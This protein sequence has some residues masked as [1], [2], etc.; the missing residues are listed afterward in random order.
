[1]YAAI[2]SRTKH[3]TH[4]DATTGGRDPAITFG[5]LFSPNGGV[6]PAQ[7]GVFV[8]GLFSDLP[9]RIWLNAQGLAWAC[10]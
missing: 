2:E 9:L 3:A 1:M 6:A 4:D 10:G 7:T 5:R 8:R